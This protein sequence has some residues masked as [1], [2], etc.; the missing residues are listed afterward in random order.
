MSRIPQAGSGD[1]QPPVGL[2]PESPQ[3]EIKEPPS[4]DAPPVTADG[5]AGE[6]YPPQGDG[7]R[8]PNRRPG[9]GN[10]LRR[11][12]RSRRKTFRQR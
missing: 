11:G 3:P 9:R 8:D 12:L 7:T 1:E 5:A 10:R 4:A 2:T 6:Q